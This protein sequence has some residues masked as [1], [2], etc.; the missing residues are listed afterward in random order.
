MK[1]KHLLSWLLLI[2]W[3]VGCATA[4]Y[5]GRRQLLLVS[6]NQELTLGYQA[7][8]EIRQRY[9]ISRD[10]ELT[11]LVQRV[12]NRIA[13]AAN[14]PDYRW[15]F[16]LFQDD[17][18]VNAFC[19]PG[20]KVGVFT[21]ILKYTQDEAG[22]ATVISHE[23]AHAILRHAGERMSQSLLAQLGSAGLGIALA[24]RSPAMVDTIQQLYGL[25]AT[26][27]F[28]LPYSRKQEYEADEVGLILMAKAG[29]DPEAALGFWRRMMAGQRPGGRMPE[30]LA[31]HPSDEKRLE[32][33][34]RLLPRIKQQYYQ[35]GTSRP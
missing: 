17:K 5:T 12:G 18:Q 7:F 30:F 8:R 6:E 35:P 29:Y 26:V 20:G 21:G 9:P 22:L 27:G 14:R 11:A 32:N 33:L 4:P 28:I 1:A 25:G 15:E 3:L 23:A 24:G 13:A 34:R 19:L 16:V 31:T 2:C 10:P